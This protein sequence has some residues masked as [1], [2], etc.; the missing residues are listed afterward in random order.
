MTGSEPGRPGAFET[1]VYGGLVVGVLDFLDASIFFTQY[2][3]IELPSVWHG[4]STGLLGPKAASEGGWPTAILGIFLHFVVAF[5]VAAVYYL[6]T[7]LLP[8]MIKWWFVFAPLY[9]LAVYFIMQNV[10]IP[11]SAAGGGSSTFRLAVF[12]NGIIGH[13]ILVGLPVAY[14]ANWSATRRR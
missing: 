7:R 1:I 11:L 4:V 3:G 2:F 8:V 14:I 12:L 13:M 6:G 9:G 5:G 10:V